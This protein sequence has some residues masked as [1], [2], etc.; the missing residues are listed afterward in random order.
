MDLGQRGSEQRVERSEQQ[1][2]AARLEAQQ[3]SRVERLLAE[4]IARI[5]R[6]SDGAA[7]TAAVAAAAG[8]ISR[9]DISAGLS[10]AFFLEC[11]HQCRALLH[12]EK[13]IVERV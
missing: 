1:R 2:Q 5:A 4:S 11:K 9:G 8:G 6:G 3:Q 13:G 7:T 10:L 12:V